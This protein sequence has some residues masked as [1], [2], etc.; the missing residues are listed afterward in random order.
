MTSQL[1]IME[2]TSTLFDETIHIMPECAMHLHGHQ[3]KILPF[4]K[5]FIFVKFNNGVSFITTLVNQ[6]MTL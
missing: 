4:M 1:P 3:N 5:P 2:K 6:L